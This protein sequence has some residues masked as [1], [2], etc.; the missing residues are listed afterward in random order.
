M[1]I[2]DRLA[3]LEEIVQKMHSKMGHKWFRREAR[4]RALH[5]GWKDCA[6]GAEKYVADPDE[7]A[8]LPT[9]YEIEERW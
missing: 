2:E 6:C 9:T 4:V 7:Y 3:A 5:D 8:E 1:H